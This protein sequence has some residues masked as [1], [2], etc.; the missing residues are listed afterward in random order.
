MYDIR[1]AG[2]HR[3][4]SCHISYFRI[5]GALHPLHISDNGPVINFVFGA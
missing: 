4:G 1:M 3:F 5:L 2:R